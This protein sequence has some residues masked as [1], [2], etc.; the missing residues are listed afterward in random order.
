M[1]D[2]PR[3]IEVNPMQIAASALASMSVAVGASFFGAT[4]TLIG[5]AIASAAIP[6]CAAVYSHYLQQTREKVRRV[7][8]VYRHRQEPGQ[9]HAGDAD[10]PAQESRGPAA[11]PAEGTQQP[12]TET[13]SDGIAARLA[14]ALR[15]TRWRGVA[16]A[17]AVVFVLAL[18][19]ITLVEALAG[20]KVA[21]MAYGKNRGG[22][23]SVG[24]LVGGGGDDS[25]PAPA[26]ATTVTE[27]VPEPESAPAT[28]EPTSPEEPAPPTTSPQP[29]PATP[30]GS[31]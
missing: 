7:T 10:T 27:T 16:V 3:R 11:S 1:V 26:P 6:I 4:G 20:D 30:D 25:E 24:G 21:T 23:T 19:T 22:S 31:G 17:V 2:K 28:P 15:A 13:A 8:V 9:T 5:G 14:A 29:I 12:E 18:G